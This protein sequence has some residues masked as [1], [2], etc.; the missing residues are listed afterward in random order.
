MQGKL[1]KC[2]PSLTLERRITTAWVFERPIPHDV[3]TNIEALV[4]QNP[5][6]PVY[7]YCGTTK[8]VHAIT[9]LGNVNIIIQFLK[10][11]NIVR[12]TSL[13]YWLAQ[14]PSI[15]CWLAKSLKI[16]YTK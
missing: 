13:A 9:E 12:D 15:N 11:T 5:D 4:D 7:V 14:H 8:C 16:I 3:I 6:V 10:V 2:V 1:R